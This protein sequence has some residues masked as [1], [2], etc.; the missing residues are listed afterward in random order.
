M[1]SKARWVIGASRGIGRVVDRIAAGVEE[2]VGIAAA[3]GE[4]FPGGVL[5]MRS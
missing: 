1:Q 5:C 4:R 2:V 3:S